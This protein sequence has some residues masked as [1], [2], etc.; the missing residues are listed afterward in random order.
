MSYRFVLP[1]LMTALCEQIVTSL[2]RVTIS[3]R[4]VELGLSV[5]W[6]G[7]ITACFA[8]LP[9]V[10][11]VQVGRFI[12]RGNDAR[13][14]WI[15]GG[16]LVAA[17][18]GFVL[19]QSLAALLFFTALLG[20]AHLLLVISQQVLCARQGGEH[21]VDR[22]IGNYMVA[23]AVGQ[24]VGPAIVGWTGGSASIPPTLLLFTIGVVFAV[25]TWACALLLRPGPPRPP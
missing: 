8:V 3:Y 25:L 22:M 13:T 17:C 21:G 6:L 18:A 1:L 15:G 12:D 4:A 9:M 11:A 10:L 24:G 16:L 5:V 23:N 20:I 14:A 19:W 2:V 7:I